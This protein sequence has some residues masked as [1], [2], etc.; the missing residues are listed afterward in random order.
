MIAPPSKPL[1]IYRTVQRLAPEAAAYVAGLVDGEGTITLSLEHRGER[2][3]IVVSISNTD[4]ALLEFV[5]ET[6][7]AGWIT[8]K[9]TYSE[10]HTPSFAYKI[11]NRQAL[12]LLS[13]I[14]RY[15]KT[16]RARRAEM[17][18]QHYVALTP[19]NGKYPEEV[20]RKRGEFEREFLA[21]GPG[22]RGRP[23]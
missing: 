1:A 22:P 17:A 8:A 23:R 9:R 4:R 2:R 7:G 11:T 5:R 3:R 6:V 16:Y 20:R 21:V 14:A 18:I 10:R 15:L 12:D 13:Q 19:R